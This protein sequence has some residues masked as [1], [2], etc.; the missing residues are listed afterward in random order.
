[1]ASSLLENISTRCLLVLNIY[2]LIWLFDIAKLYMI[3]LRKKNTKKNMTRYFSWTSC[4]RTY[5]RLLHDR[6][7]AMVQRIQGP[8]LSSH[9]FQVSSSLSRGEKG[10]A[11]LSSCLTL[12]FF[13]LHHVGSNSGQRV[14]V[15]TWMQWQVRVFQYTYRTLIHLMK[16][17]DRRFY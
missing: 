12:L 9:S 10:L 3:F 11:S 1:M 16:R 13:A 5:I 8:H 6:L 17:L 7:N 15:R 14:C 2:A 4:S